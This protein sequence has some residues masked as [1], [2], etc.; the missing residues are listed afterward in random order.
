MSYAMSRFA[1]SCLVLLLNHGGWEW[2]MRLAGQHLTPPRGVY[3]TLDAD[4]FRLCTIGGNPCA[5]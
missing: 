3:V 4:S 1:I 5:L 2:R